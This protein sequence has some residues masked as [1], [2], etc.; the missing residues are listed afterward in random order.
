MLNRRGNQ[1]YGDSPADIRDLIRRYSEANGYPAE[2]Y[3]DPMCACGNRVFRLRVDDDEGAAVRVCTSCGA[4]HPIGDSND[5]LADAALEE[6]ECPCGQSS[7]ELSVGVALYEGSRD[8]RWLY[9]G[10]R[11]PSCGVTGCY[12]D[13]KNEFN[14]YIELLRRV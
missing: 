3:A 12:G 2:H 13:W 7:F 11:C 10:C 6:C 9:I 14:D 4:L 1:W 8:V 5:Y